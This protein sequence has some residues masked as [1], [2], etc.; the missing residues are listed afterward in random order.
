IAYLRIDGPNGLKLIDDCIL[1][2]KRAPF[3][4]VYPAITALRFVGQEEPSRF[5]SER[6]VKSF[7]HVL[8]RADY[9]DLVIPDLARWEDWS[10][11][12]QLVQIF[13]DAT[14]ENSW[15][16]VPVIQYLKACPLPKAKSY[17][18]ELEK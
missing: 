7:R 1:A 5:S 12:D 11:M 2:K 6:I 15:I 13:K 18:A 14:S 3:C 9:A 16:R 17:I 8:D 10:V 4:E